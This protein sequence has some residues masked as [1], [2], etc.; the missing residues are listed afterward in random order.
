ML[1]RR[2]VI[3]GLLGTF[4]AGL[5]AATY[6][7]FIEPALRFRVRRW[8][9]RHA[10]WP[11]DKPLKVAVVADLHMGDPYVPLARLE[12]IV[13]RTNALGADLIVILG[14]LTAG[15][16]FV[17]GTIPPGDTAAVLARLSA[18]L[19][20]CAVLG[21][22]DWW[23]DP[24]AQKRKRGPVET[25][26]AL[27][28]HGIPVLENQ[29]IEL[30]NGIWVA[31]LGDQLALVQGRGRYTGVD[32]LPATLDQVPDGAPAILLAHEPDIFPK[33]PDRIPLTLS[34]HTHGGQ[35]RLFGWSPI[36][37]SRFGNRFAYGHVQEG[38][39]H[40]VVSGGIGSSI[41]PVRFGVVPEITLV[42]LT[43]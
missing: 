14:D 2:H 10:D 34:G 25:G 4:L 6:G 35:V 30:P 31:G 1:T 38:T 3:K 37:P 22:H 18:P 42:T 12:R 39:R 33:V 21:N 32:D 15:H 41:M 7:F 26:I 24:Q 5:F 11:M 8:T 43:A 17:T 28:R 13:A 19:G 36:V 29:A 23:D 27:E 9:V 20:V 16:R 40:L